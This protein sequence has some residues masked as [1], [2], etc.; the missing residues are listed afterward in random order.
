MASRVNLYV[1]SASADTEDIKDYLSNKGIDFHVY[2]IG[3]DVDAHKRMIEATRGAGGPP[4][5]EVGHQ[6]VI[7]F[8]KDRLEETIDY[9]FR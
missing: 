8:D 7:G 2:D 4:V 6:V 3:S 9:E 1:S 5:I